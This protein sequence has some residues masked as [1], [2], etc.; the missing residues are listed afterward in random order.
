MS[1]I[2]DKSIYKHLNKRKNKTLSPS[3]AY[4]FQLT[5]P[6]PDGPMQK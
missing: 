2:D 1:V 6:T 3:E 5:L 4:N